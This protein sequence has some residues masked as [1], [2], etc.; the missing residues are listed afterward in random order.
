MENI[1]IHLII[2]LSILPAWVIAYT[3]RTLK[4]LVFFTFSISINITI[5]TLMLAGKL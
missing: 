1:F 4:T 2:I 3:D 5:I